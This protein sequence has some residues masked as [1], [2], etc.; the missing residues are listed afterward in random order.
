MAGRA[1]FR[2]GELKVALHLIDRC[3][4]SSDGGGG[5]VQIFAPSVCSASLEAALST[6]FPHH[7]LCN[8]RCNL[9]HV[10]VF[11]ILLAYVCT[12]M[13]ALPAIFL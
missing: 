9:A 7:F 5:G 11:F 2:K 13:Y 12:D 3:R 8:G 4:G 10:F 6:L 1:L